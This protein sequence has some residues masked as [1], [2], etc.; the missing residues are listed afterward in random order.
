M[1]SCLS[2]RTFV[3]LSPVKFVKPFAT[4]QHL[5]ASTSFSYRPESY[6]PKHTA[7]LGNLVTTGSVSRSS[8][9]TWHPWLRPLRSRLRHC[10]AE[11]VAGSTKNREI[12]IPHLYSTPSYGEPRRSFTR[13]FSIVKTRIIGLP[14]AEELMLICKAV[15]LFR[16]NTGTRRTDGRRYGQTHDR[17]SIS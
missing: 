14:H 9:A 15:K 3:R 11:A 12:C 16:Y 5:A 7:C 6:R 1:S 10:A 2:V 13:M 8:G 17:I 4:W